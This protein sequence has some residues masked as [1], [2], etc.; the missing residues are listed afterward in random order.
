LSKL[1][2]H[3]SSAVKS[4]GALPSDPAGD[5]LLTNKLREISARKRYD[6]PVPQSPE[7]V[8]RRQTL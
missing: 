3:I 2:D 1:A 4:E 8:G 7:I 6:D 5:N